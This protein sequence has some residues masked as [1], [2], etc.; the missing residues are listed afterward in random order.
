MFMYYHFRL[1]CEFS[2]ARPDWANKGCG[3]LMWWQL[4]LLKFGTKCNH[5]LCSSSN[6]KLFRNKSTEAQP[7]PVKI[8]IWL[9]LKF[10]FK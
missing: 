8:L 4:K 6:K 2:L 3:M 10:V 9:A 5:Y 7:P 1:W